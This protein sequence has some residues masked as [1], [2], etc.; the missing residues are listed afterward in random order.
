MRYHRSQIQIRNTGNSDRTFRWNK[1]HNAIWAE[2]HVVIDISRVS[3]NC[4][5]VYFRKFALTDTPNSERVWLCRV[6]NF[7]VL[8]ISPVCTKGASLCKAQG[9]SWSMREFAPLY[10]TNMS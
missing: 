8:A 3:S 5:T 7:P 4:H 2:P 6:M 9:I 10:T 1:A